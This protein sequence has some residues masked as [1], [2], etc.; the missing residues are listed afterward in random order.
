MEV[1]RWTHH[2]TR[3]IFVY[4]HRVVLFYEGSGYVPDCRYRNLEN[5][6][7]APKAQDGSTLRLSQYLFPERPASI[8]RKS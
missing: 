3:R 2:Q 5:R 4:V 7:D 8:L 6:G 1:M